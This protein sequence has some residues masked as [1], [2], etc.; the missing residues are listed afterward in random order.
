MV[1]SCVRVRFIWA[2]FIFTPSLVAF[3]WQVCLPGECEFGL[4]WANFECGVA[5]S[6]TWAAAAVVGGVVAVVVV[7]IAVAQPSWTLAEATAMVIGVPKV[8][9]LGIG[10]QKMMMVRMRWY[11]EAVAR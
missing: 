7:A 9:A 8:V 11:D 2:I 10:Q 6:R 5:Y 1:G 4:M 3:T